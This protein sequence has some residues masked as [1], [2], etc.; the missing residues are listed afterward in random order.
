MPTLLSVSGTRCCHYNNLQYCQWWQ[1]GILTTLGFLWHQGVIFHQ[2]IMY[3]EDPK[4][5]YQMKQMK[6]PKY[7]YQMKQMTMT[8]CTGQITLFGVNPPDG[9]WV[10]SSATLQEHLLC[11][12]ACPWGLDGQMTVTL[13]IYRPKWSQWT[14]FGVNKIWWL[15]LVPT[16]TTRFASDVGCRMAKY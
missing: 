16:P 1:N 7:W 8:L 12:W 6:D 3:E 13:H 2:C 9:C 10:S 15:C 4:Y 14:W 11:P 5:W